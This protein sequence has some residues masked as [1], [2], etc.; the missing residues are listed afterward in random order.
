MYKRWFALA[1]LLLAF[2]GA[3]S[4][5]DPADALLPVEQAF[6]LEARVVDPGRIELRWDI[7]PDY[8]LYR[9]RIKTR[10]AQPGLNLGELA[11]PDGERHADEFF[12]EVE[13]YHGALEATLPYSLA[14]PDEHL[15]LTVTVQ[16]CHEV[17]PLVCYPPHPTE[18]NLALP[19]VAAADSN[20]F[21]GISA[22][23]NLLGGEGKLLQLGS[24][25][26]N[27]PL[28]ADQAFQFEVI[29]AGPGELLARWTMPKGY[30]LYRD[31]SALRLLDGQ[32]VELGAP[33]WPAGVQHHDEHFGDV[34]VYFDQVEL[35]ISLARKNGRPEAITLEAEYQG[36]QD[37]GICYPVMAQQ[38]TL[39]LPA[40]SEAELAAA[41][42]AFVAPVVAAPD[43]AEMANP[44]RETRPAPSAGSILL[45]LLAALGGGLILN[46]MPCVLPVLSLKVLGVAQS[47]GSRTAA[48]RHALIYTAGT[49][50]AFAAVGLVV[51]GL[52]G[53]G[54]ALG[55]GFQLQQPLFVAALVYVMFAIGLALSGVVNLG[56]G[57]AGTGGRFAGRS[58]PLGDF[59]TG[60][61]AVV[62]ASPCT[63]PFMGAAL[64]FAF[65]A[66]SLV[67]LLIFLALGL[68]LA[69]PFLVVGFVPGVARFLPRPGA[70]METLKQFLAFPMY[71]TAVWLLWVLGNQRGI[72]AVA[73][74]LIGAVVLAL[75]LW[76]WEHT[77]ARGG[78]LARALAVAALLVA[79][80]PL[81]R[82]SSLAPP[83]P[84]HAAAAQQ[85]WVPYSARAL[86]NLR[87]EGRGVFVDVGADWCVTCKVNEKAVLDSDAF[88]ALLK[89]SNTVPMK[90]DWTNADPQISAFLDQYRAVGVPLYVVFRAGVDGAGQVLPTLLTQAIVEQALEA[91]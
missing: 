45:A 31:K 35:P 26:E 89:R 66:S 62:V 10:S 17:E 11:L 75:G 49:L 81:A 38:T 47:S 30:Y 29:P 12:G 68:G 69:L 39:E 36:C 74:V 56:A 63:A 54:H 7:A 8:Y 86:A 33:A 55:W 51:I 4:A 64:A 5:Q 42:A 48:R 22:S 90:A 20:P 61:L 72:D 88:R 25:E 80:W 87:A 3:A 85:D 67:A 60:V 43:D 44:P 82:V 37:E 57:L 9:S 53:A 70:W 27:L 34:E 65:A 16:G 77:R 84:A 15:K 58:G 83:A 40:A 59:F 71:L 28:P 23:A 24:G 52:R 76:W 50:S 46:L 78:A 32:G 1:P 19:A 91:P 21:A 18:L 41:N 13:I 2:S 73:W 6:A 79:L 14:G